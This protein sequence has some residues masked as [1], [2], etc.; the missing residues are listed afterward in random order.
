L[1]IVSYDNCSSPLDV[2]S[3]LSTAWE[4]YKT[5]GGPLGHAFG[6]EGG[7]QGKHPEIAT[8]M[9]ILDELAICRWIGS[10]LRATRAA[11]KKT[12]I[13]DLIQ[14]AAEKFDRSDV[15]IRRAWRRFGRHERERISV[16]HNFPK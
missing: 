5:E 3:P 14:E 12:R 2:D 11:Q 4:K 9:Q 6:L 7:G 8:M 13:E 10:Q 1:D 16:G 15:T